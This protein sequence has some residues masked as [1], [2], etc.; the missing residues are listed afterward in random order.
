MCFDNWVGKNKLEL[1][2]IPDFSS[3]D[4]FIPVLYNAGKLFVPSSLY[5][6]NA[7]NE[8]YAHFDKCTTLLK[9]GDC[10]LPLKWF[11][12]EFQDDSDFIKFCKSIR[13][14]VMENVK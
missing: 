6:N 9:N 4:T 13:L 12:T 10:F 3:S 1:D 14:Q 2:I 11:E 7:I 8:L 5:G